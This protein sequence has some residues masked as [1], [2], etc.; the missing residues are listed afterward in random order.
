MQ[1]LSNSLNLMNSSTS[2]Q[3]YSFSKSPRFRDVN[4]SMYFCCKSGVMCFM[5]YQLQEPK[6][7]HPLGLEKKIWGYR[8]IKLCPHLRLTTSQVNSKMRKRVSVLEKAEKIW[9][10]QAQ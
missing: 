10:L 1:K 4:K 7:Q 3:R 2:K 9:K 5:T 8:L 6:D